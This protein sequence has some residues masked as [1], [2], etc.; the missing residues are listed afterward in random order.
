MAI[1]YGQH[2]QW[3]DHILCQGSIHLTLTGEGAAMAMAM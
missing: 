3:I 1:D 2:K